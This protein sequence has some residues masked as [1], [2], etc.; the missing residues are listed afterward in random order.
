MVYRYI[1]STVLFDDLKNNLIVLKLGETPLTLLKADTTYE[2]SRQ[3]HFNF[4]S[5][6]IVVTHS[7]LQNKDVT[8]KAIETYDSMS[9]FFYDLF[10]NKLEVCSF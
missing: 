5:E 1:G 10:G 3:P 9:S 7:Q 8:V 4:F 6:N 2:R